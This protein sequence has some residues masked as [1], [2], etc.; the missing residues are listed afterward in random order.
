MKFGSI[1]TIYVYLLSQHGKMKISERAIHV[2]K[3]NSN[4]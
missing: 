4:R 2:M 1:L 3:N